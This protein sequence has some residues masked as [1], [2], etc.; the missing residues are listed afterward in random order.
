MNILKS[1][2]IKK[3][4]VKKNIHFDNFF[5]FCNAFKIKNITSSPL[6]QEAMTHSS[7]S[8]KC[9]Y[10]R[11]EF[12]G[13]TLLNFCISKMI[14]EN[15]PN[16]KEGEMS[17]IKSFVISRKVCREV[18]NKIHLYEKI[19]KSKR[20]NVDNNVI[21]ADIMES[22]L[23]CVYYEYGIIKVYEIVK[24]IFMDYLKSNNVFDPKMELQEITQ[25]LYKCFPEYKILE[26]K[27]TEHNPLFVVQA[28]VLKFSTTASGKNIKEAEKESA[29]K[30]IEL[31]SKKR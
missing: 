1:N 2:N 26:K 16:A 11:M 7:L 21:I 3:G 15:F 17:K 20:Q 5:Q 23:C 9:N 18:A 29:K 12:L 6:F 8:K 28:S 30:L 22:F 24:A 19:I 10:E 31:L 14:F 4:K 27:G 25:K 13:D